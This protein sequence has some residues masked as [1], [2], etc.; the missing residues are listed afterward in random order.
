MDH[1]NGN[2]SPNAGR[3]ARP[4]ESGENVAEKSNGKSSV[5]SRLP[6]A[7]EVENFPPDARP[8]PTNPLPPRKDQML[9]AQSPIKRGLPSSVNIEPPAKEPNVLSPTADEPI[10][11]SC[12]TKSIS[13]SY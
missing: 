12:C 6:T 10:A 11:D 2:S 9:E 3:F 7:E 13:D 1:H 8:V 4:M 5:S